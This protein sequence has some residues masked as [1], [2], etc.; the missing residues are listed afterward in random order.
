MQVLGIESSCDETAIAL[1]AN[2]LEIRAN[3]IASQAELHARY[4]GVIPEVAARRHIE[5][6]SP[7]LAEAM[8]QSKAAWCDL[9]AVA[10]TRGPGL[11]GALLVGLMAAKGIAWSLGLP[12]IGVN[13]L[14]AH[15][16]ANRMHEA[17]LPLPFQCLL[18]SG[19]HTA[20]VLVK[21]P[22]SMVTLGH[23]RDDAVG[24]A[25]DKVARLLDLGYPGGPAIDRLA[26]TG[27][28]QAFALPRAW[29]EGTWDFSLSGLKA[30]VRRLVERHRLA[31]IPLA[32]ADLAAAFQQAVIDVLVNKTINAALAHGVTTIAIAGG[33]AANSTLRATLGAACAQ[34]GWKFSAPPLALCTDNAAMI[35]GLGYECLLAGRQDSLTVGVLPR[36][37]L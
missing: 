13:H 15:I 21:G 6:L 24:E 11:A 35:A 9:G 19:G 16:W 18:V 32:V 23:T 37:P 3:V 8:A 34:R 5:L 4:G 28:P 22:T 10:V 2:G 27:D 29:L 14:A 1:V 30:A 26:Q 20:L 17:D 36:W 7:L 12:L 31:G 25:Y 33:V